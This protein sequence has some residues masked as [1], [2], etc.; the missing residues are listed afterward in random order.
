MWERIFERYARAHDHCRQPD[1]IGIGLTISRDLAR[2][3][4]GDLTYSY[5]DGWSTFE[6]TLPVA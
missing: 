3:M 1:S 5:V 6:L 4:D 2:L